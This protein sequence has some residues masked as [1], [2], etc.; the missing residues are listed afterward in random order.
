MSI[1]YKNNETGV[2]RTQKQLVEWAAQELAANPTQYKG[3][4]RL[5]SADTTKQTEVV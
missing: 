1:C 2:V 3:L 4:A 5:L